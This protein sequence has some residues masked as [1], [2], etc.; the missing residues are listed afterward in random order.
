MENSGTKSTLSEDR[1]HLRQLQEWAAGSDNQY[2]PELLIASSSYSGLFDDDL[3]NQLLER[4]YQVENQPRIWLQYAHS[5]LPVYKKAKNDRYKIKFLSYIYHF[6]EKI[7]ISW[8]TNCNPVIKGT[9]LFF[10]ENLPL[11]IEKLC[12]EE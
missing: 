11:E 2:V 9:G 10:R 12:R 3:I 4:L 1:E 5:I 6:N 8:Q 7:Q